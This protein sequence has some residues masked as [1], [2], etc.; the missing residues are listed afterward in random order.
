MKIIF[1]SVSVL[2]CAFILFACPYESVVPIDSP[3]VPLDKKLIG[4]WKKLNAEDESY[5][6][7]ERDEYT[8]NIEKRGKSE[9]DTEHFW[10][11][12]S[13]V[14]GIRFL[15]ILRVGPIDTLSKFFFYKIDLN[16]D[17]I[18]L[19][20]LTENIDE[21]FS[22]SASLKNFIS[23]NLKNTYFFNKEEINYIRVL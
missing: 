11:Y 12:E 21:E 22:T 15:N 23:I 16:T 20:E 8:F 13:H 9:S 1:Q 17:S 14:D 3:T 6:I 4:T 19:F 2:L 18:R 5:V 7:S 10:G